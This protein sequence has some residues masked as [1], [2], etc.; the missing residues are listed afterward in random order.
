MTGGSFAGDA[1]TVGYAQRKPKFENG[2]DTGR[3]S[4]EK[5]ERQ[6]PDRNKTDEQMQAERVIE[7]EIKEVTEVRK[8][9][10]KHDK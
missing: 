7:Q 5:D 1:E 2:W 9:N 10:R 3:N 8:E 6:K 4:S